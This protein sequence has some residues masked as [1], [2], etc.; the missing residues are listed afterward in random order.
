MF[1]TK[2]ILA[3]LMLIGFGTAS[4]T[5]SKVLVSTKTFGYP[6]DS[7]SNQY[8]AYLDNGP[9]RFNKSFSISFIM[10]IG[11]ALAYPVWIATTYFEAKRKGE[12]FSFP[13]RSF[14]NIISPALP[15]ACDCTATTLNLYAL[16]Y[17]AASTESMLSG[18]QILFTALLS[19]FFLKKKIWCYQL[20]AIF[21]AI[22]ALV[23]IGS[24]ELGKADS[25][26]GTTAQRALGIGLI[27][28]GFLVQSIQNVFLEK[29]LEGLEPL[30]I[31][32]LQGIWGTVI[33]LVICV[34][35][36]YFIQG[37]EFRAGIDKNNNALTS[38][39]SIVDTFYRVG[40]NSKLAALYFVYLFILFFFNIGVIAVV[41]Y[42]SAINYTIVITVR[43]LLVWVIFLI[44]G[45]VVGPEGK[46]GNYSYAE[47]WT[48]FSFLQLVG[49][50][51]NLLA[52]II[53]NRFIQFPCL[54]YPDEEEKLD[55]DNSQEDE[56]KEEE[57]ND[58][59]AAENA[60]AP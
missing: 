28:I 47:L 20:I 19:F 37:D 46:E 27:I 18:S 48:N 10:F 56:K 42:T 39:E 16:R 14:L 21:A 31:V 36:A 33:V 12:K 58:E 8:Q 6:P 30:E 29:I 45:A 22:C 52:T 17:V 3:M 25:S 5:I 38:F 7:G 26:E 11:M 32:G 51:I 54:P 4:T 55:N 23:F 24:A 13:K 59:N 44:V 15:A 41:N 35:A 1:N 49:F 43:S 60:V 34:P 9:T 57:E 2:S 40:K 53:N 50:I